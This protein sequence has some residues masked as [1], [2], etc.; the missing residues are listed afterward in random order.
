MRFTLQKLLANSSSQKLPAKK[1]TYPQTVNSI[2]PVLA[3]LGQRFFGTKSSRPEHF[4]DLVYSA[5]EQSL[6]TSV[7]HN[8]MK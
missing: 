8:E 7:T 1:P 5:P 3:F 2:C 4:A 6:C